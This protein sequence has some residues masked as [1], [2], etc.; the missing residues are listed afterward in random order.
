MRHLLLAGSILLLTLA[1]CIGAMVCVNTGVDRVLT[2]LE[3]AWEAAQQGD[4]EGAAEAIGQAQTVWE[5]WEA[6]LAVFIPHEDT[7]QVTQKLSALYQYALTEDDDEFAAV[8]A[9]AAFLL[10]HLKEMQTL[11]VHNVL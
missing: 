5:A 7:D 2:P 9:E 1:I 3:R 8:Y 10:E 11:R 4:F 6:A